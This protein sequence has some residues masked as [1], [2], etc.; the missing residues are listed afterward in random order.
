[1]Y[2]NLA[3]YCIVSEGFQRSIL[4]GQDVLLWIYTGYGKC[5]IIVPLLTATCEDNPAIGPS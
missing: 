4:Y 2:I 1:M 5:I 3:L